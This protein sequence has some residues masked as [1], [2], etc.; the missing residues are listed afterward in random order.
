MLKVPDCVLFAGNVSYI[1]FTINQS[2]GLELPLG[3]AKNSL[4]LQKKQ[5]TKI[6]QSLSINSLELC[7]PLSQVTPAHQGHF[8]PSFNYNQISFNENPVC[9]FHSYKIVTASYIL[10]WRTES[11]R[12]N[13][14]NL[15]YLYVL[16]RSIIFIFHSAFLTNIKTSIF[17]RVVTSS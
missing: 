12:F 3:P 8:Q 5:P 7:P 10:R 13:K 11:Y 15:L 14:W 17:F 2:G 9:I 6:F 1:P 4:L 16:P